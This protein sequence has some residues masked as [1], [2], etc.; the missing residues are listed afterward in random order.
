MANKKIKVLITVMLM[1][2]VFTSC[3]IFNKNQIGVNN[4][5]HPIF[6]IENFDSNSFTDSSNLF[7]YDLL[8]SISKKEN[9]ELIT[10]SLT[11]TPNTD[12]IFNDVTVTAS[13]DEAW[14]N[15]L[16]DKN[17]NTLFF[18]TDKKQ[19]ILMDRNSESNK[20]LISDVGKILEEG[21]APE[22]IK[23]LLSLPI[24]I[25]IKFQDKIITETVIP[26]KIL[27]YGIEE[28]SV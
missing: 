2:I 8:S 22:Q 24:K 18:G 27:I 28:K 14:M 4:Q 26:N 13:L 1:V 17:R 11:I 23:N 21:V 10:Y 12:Q 25:R 9:N 6:D 19:P 3:N 20:G 16:Q 15:W 5:S 7:K